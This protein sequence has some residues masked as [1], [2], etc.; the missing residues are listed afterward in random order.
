LTSKSALRHSG[1]QLF[2][3]WLFLF[4]DFLPFHLSKLWEVWLLKLPS[5]KWNHHPCVH[6][7]NVIF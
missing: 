1:V 6:F 4:S 3:F 5:V 2:I 7:S